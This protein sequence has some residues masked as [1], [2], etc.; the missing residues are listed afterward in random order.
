M[1]YVMGKSICIH[2]QTYVRVHM[3]TPKHTTYTEMFFVCNLGKF[4]HWKG[5]GQ[6]ISERYKPFMY[7]IQLGHEM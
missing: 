5:F 1:I 2:T 4:Y 7:R 3:Y 6:A